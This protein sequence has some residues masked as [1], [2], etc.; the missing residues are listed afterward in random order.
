MR[1]RCRQRLRN[2]SYLYTGWGR[3]DWKDGEDKKILVGNVAW[4]RLLCATASDYPWRLSYVEWKR[5]EFA[6]GIH[7]VCG[8]R[9]GRR[10]DFVIKA[11]RK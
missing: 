10:D 1:R 6:D 2:L 9:Y 3:C 8:R 7:P 11:L 4:H 5:G